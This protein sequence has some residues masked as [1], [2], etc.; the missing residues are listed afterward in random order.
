MAGYNDKNH[1]GGGVKVVTAGHKKVN[2]S[3]GLS[4]GKKNV[5]P[6]SFADKIALPSA[7]S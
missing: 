1:G 4:G 2:K 5:N 3:A 6:S 7:K